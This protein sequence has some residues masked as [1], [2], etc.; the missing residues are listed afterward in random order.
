[1]IVIHPVVVVLLLLLLLALTVLAPAP[2]IAAAATAAGGGDWRRRCDGSGGGGGG[3][4]C[5][6]VVRDGQR[7]RGAWPIGAGHGQSFALPA[8]WCQIA[9]V[10]LLGVSLKAG[11]VGSSLF[12]PIHQREQ[13]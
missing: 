10:L 7:D 4:G 3:G 12:H 2:A 5:G 13:P 11:P 9:I 6:A 8:N 1:I